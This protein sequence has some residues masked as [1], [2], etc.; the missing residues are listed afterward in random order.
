MKLVAT[1]MTYVFEKDIKVVFETS[2]KE[3]FTTATVY[4]KDK[5][6]EKSKGGF[7]PSLERARACVNP[8]LLND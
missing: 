6:I 2:A 8:S 3:D 1:T 7:V 5:E 4:K